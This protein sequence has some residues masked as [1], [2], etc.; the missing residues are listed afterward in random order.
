[1]PQFC[2]H[3]LPTKMVPRTTNQEPPFLF[4]K[5]S[6]IYFFIVSYMYTTHLDHICLHFPLPSSSS[7]R[8]FNTFSMPLHL[9]LSFYLSLSESYL[10]QLALLARMLTDVDL[11]LHR[12][13]SFLNLPVSTSPSCMGTWISF[14]L[15]LK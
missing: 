8:T 5:I 15:F 13:C 4:I 2:L 3:S 12:S 1:M 6:F 9:S 10:V 11:L 14:L 7:Q